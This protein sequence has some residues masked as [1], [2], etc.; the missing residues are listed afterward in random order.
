MTFVWEGKKWNCKGICLQLGV[1]AINVQFHHLYLEDK[2]VFDGQS[3]V[4]KI[5]DH[6]GG[7]STE[8]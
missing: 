8:H 3:N 2:I 6:K 7:T 4:K 5:W 1:D